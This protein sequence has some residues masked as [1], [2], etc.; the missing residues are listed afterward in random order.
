[1]LAACKQCKV[2]LIDAG[3]DIDVTVDKVYRYT[4]KLLIDAGGDVN[5]ADKVFILINLV[6][7]YDLMCNMSLKL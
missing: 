4:V 1:M 5:K 2:E 6:F 3:I 7:L